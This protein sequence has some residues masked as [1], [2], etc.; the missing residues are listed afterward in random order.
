M[1]IMRARLLNSQ[2][3]SLAA[4]TITACIDHC[5]VLQPAA[6]TLLVNM[7]SASTSCHAGLNSLAMGMFGVAGAGLVLNY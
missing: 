1:P 2:I 6:C 4:I 3:V 5:I 7:L